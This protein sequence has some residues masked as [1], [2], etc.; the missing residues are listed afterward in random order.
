MSSKLTQPLLILAT[1]AALIPPLHAVEYDIQQI[2]DPQHVNREPVISETGLIAWYAHQKGLPTEGGGSQIYTHV[3]NQTLRVTTKDFYAYSANSRPIVYNDTILW[4]TTRNKL[5]TGHETTWVLREVPDDLR[6]KD[7]K[8][9]PA[10]YVNADLLV[11]KGTPG[12]FNLNPEGQS[13]AGPFSNFWE[14]GSAFIRKEADKTN[15]VAIAV[16]NNVENTGPWSVKTKEELEADA[17][18]TDNKAPYTSDASIKS[19]RRTI[20]FNE[21]CR[22]S[23]D[24]RKIEWVTHDQR[25]DMGPSLWEDIIT[26]QKSKAFPFGWE[27]MALVATQRF[28]LTTNFYYDMAPKVHGRDIAWYGWDGNDYEIF[29]WNAD[30]QIVRQI[31]SNSYD[32]VSPVIWDGMIAWE[33]YPAVEAEIYVWEPNDDRTD[34]TLKQISNNVDD[35]FNPIIWNKKVVWQ[36][37]DGDD[38]EIFLYDPAKKQKPVQKLTNNLYDDVNASFCHDVLTWMGYHDAWDAEI[39]VW[40]WENDTAQMITDNE[41]EDKNP[42]TCNGKIVWQADNDEQSEIYV[43]TPK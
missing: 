4:Q 25:N 38:F 7:F 43:A 27:I 18:K 39:F 37:F 42:K 16:S 20:T 1:I 32:D 13:F 23:A 31:T 19:R 9:L 17:Y 28:Q 30:E 33:G 35:D 21:L 22:W 24:E 5:D 15:M 6:D 12:D 40:D 11:A 41:F 26:W 8:E 36:G 29:T 10:F 14:Y 34:G 2:A 3:D